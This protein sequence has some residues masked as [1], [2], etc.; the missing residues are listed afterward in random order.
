VYYLV[1][2]RARPAVEL[3]VIMV[4]TDL[5]ELRQLLREAVDASRMYGRDIEDALEIGHGNLTRLLNGTLELRVRHLLAF[6]RLLKIPPAEL[7]ELGCPDAARIAQHR[8]LDWLGPDRRR[9]AQ[10][11]SRP[12]ST[13]EEFTEL[14][15]TVVREEIAALQA[16]SGKSSSSRR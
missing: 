16:D 5:K 9:A 12:S 4:D 10:D 6:A 1:A 15:R 3:A 11:G 8:L 7:L 2:E 14:I 13:P